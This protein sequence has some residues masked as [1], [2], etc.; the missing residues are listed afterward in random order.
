MKWIKNLILRNKKNKEEMMTEEQ[1]ISYKQNFTGQRF[2]WI[3]TDRPELVG[4]IVKCRDVQHQG[5]SAI[6]VFEDGSKID[7]K[8]LNKNLLMITGDMQPLSKQEAM[9]IGGANRPSQ[10]APLETPPSGSGPIKIPDELKEYQTKNEPPK[11]NLSKPQSEPQ[12]PSEP[13][14]NPFEM[15]NSEETEIVLKMNVKIPDKKLL[16][17]MY[18]NAEN[19][20]EFVDQLAAYIYSLINNNTVVDSLESIFVSKPKSRARVVHKKSDT[21][22]IKLTEVDDE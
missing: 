16:K 3:K 5:R 20:E 11:K 12:R 13:A 21:E 15:F 8:L 2:Q 6:A 1:L 22:D 19:K 10:Q 9:S 4:K 7:I 14:K 18:S 17:L